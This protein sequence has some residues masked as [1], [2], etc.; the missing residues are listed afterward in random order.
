MNN[1]GKGERRRE[2]FIYCPRLTGQR[3]ESRNVCTQSSVGRGREIY[4]AREMERERERRNE[5]NDRQGLEGYRSKLREKD[6]KIDK[7]RAW[8]NEREDELRIH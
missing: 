8:E 7:K 1:C 5:R 3:K 6:R 2:V 4:R